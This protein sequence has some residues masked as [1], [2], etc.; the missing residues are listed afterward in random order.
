MADLG[1]ALAPGSVPY[2]E[3]DD[4]EAGMAEVQAGAPGPLGGGSAPTGAQPA[5]EDD[6]VFD[7]DQF[8]LGGGHSS[9][10]PITAGLDVGPGPGPF[11]GIQATSQQKKLQELALNS[12]SAALRHAARLALRRLGSGVS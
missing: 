9:D 10:L 6:E 2:G 8:L 11:G 12:P 7:P 3:R 5:I 1:R 4:L